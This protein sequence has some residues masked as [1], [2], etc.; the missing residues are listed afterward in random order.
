MY[1]RCARCSSGSH[2]AGQ[3]VT[4]AGVLNSRR[5]ALGVKIDWAYSP[6]EVKVLTSSDG[7][8]FEEAKCWQPAARSEVAYA[9]SI[10]FDTPLPVKAI[11]ISM[12]SPLSW[13]YFG[14][15]SVALLASP[16]P[17]M[18]VRHVAVHE[19]R[20]RIT[21]VCICFLNQWHH[22]SGW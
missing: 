11:T 14:I 20:K 8:N 15:N 7:S 13:G 9:E 3:T 5:Q 19:C 16:G 6:G 4:W 18:L 17:F 22:V 10:M 1:V 21:C 12:R 2:G